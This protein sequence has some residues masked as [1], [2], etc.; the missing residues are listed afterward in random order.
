MQR[1]AIL[2]D[3]LSYT[4]HDRACCFAGLL[5]FLRRIVVVGF[6]ERFVLRN[7]FIHVKNTAPACSSEKKTTFHKL[8]HSSAGFRSKR[9]RPRT[10]ATPCFQRPEILGKSF[11]RP[12]HIPSCYKVIH[13]RTMPAA[14]HSYLEHLPSWSNLSLSK[15]NVEA[16]VFPFRYT[17]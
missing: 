8:P 3:D 17:C 2:V 13:I 12:Y 5:L 9:K 4:S 14:E 6:L 10:K 16:H 11:L 15:E 7:C 1:P